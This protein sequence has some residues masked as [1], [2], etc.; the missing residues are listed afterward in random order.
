MSEAKLDKTAANVKF[1][2]D[3]FQAWHKGRMD[4]DGGG[5][6][7]FY[8]P[9]VKIFNAGKSIVSG[10]FDG[11]ADAHVRY[12]VKIDEMTVPGSNHGLVG[13]P[14]IL[15]AGDEFAITVVYE[16]HHRVGKEP[17][18]V[19]R[20]ALYEIQDEKITA[21]RC[22]QFDQAAWDAYYA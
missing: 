9:D 21:I 12:F 2:N 18:V 7:S 14:V 11:I 15:S 20:M 8:A 5:I 3:Y 16:T 6:E 19:S 10:N 22:Y 4:G 17:L 1:M 13:N